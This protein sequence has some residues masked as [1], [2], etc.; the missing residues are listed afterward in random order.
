MHSFSL[1]TKQRSGISVLGSVKEPGFL[2]GG[3]FFA[4]GPD[5]CF[6]GIGLRSNWEACHQ[7]MK[8]DMFGTKSVAI[9][10]DLFDQSQDRMHLDCVFNIVGY[11]CCLML[12]DILNTTSNRRRLVDEY[13]KD[14][15]TGEYKRI[16]QDIEFGDYVQS[17]GFKI[18]PVSS[19][20]QVKY[21]CNVLNLGHGRIL[22][23]NE[24]SGRKI[25]RSPSF[26]GHVQVRQTHTRLTNGE[27][28]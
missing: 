24:S 10:K 20:D 14:P 16:V 21:G 23:V 17:K 28:R 2:E 3:D 13:A 8:Q 9:V 6:V 22:S 15:K 26:Q 18:I 27:S 11:D 7:L 19:E 4:A 5:L 25:L 12:E 1:L